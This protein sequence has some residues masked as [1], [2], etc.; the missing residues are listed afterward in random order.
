MVVTGRPLNG[1]WVEVVMGLSNEGQLLCWVAGVMEGQ[2][3]ERWRADAK[4]FR[5]VVNRTHCATLCL[6]Q[7]TV[8]NLKS[9][10]CKLQ[11]GF[12]LD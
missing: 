11:N 7:S 9:V 5:Q 2:H 1:Q 3:C 4:P 10:N 8:R 12:I 6:S